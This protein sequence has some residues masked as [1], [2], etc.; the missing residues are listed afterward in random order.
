MRGPY[1]FCR[2]P[3][4]FPARGLKERGTRLPRN[5]GTASGESTGRKPGGWDEAA[6]GAV[7]KEAS[8]EMHGAGGK[9]RR[10]AT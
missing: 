8:V 6:V 5:G 3:E 7:G 1:V 9:L 4:R 2:R 10:Y